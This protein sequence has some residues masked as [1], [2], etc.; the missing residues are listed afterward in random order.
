MLKDALLFPFRGTSLFVLILFSV[1]I[2]LVVVVMTLAYVLTE[3]QPLWMISIP[4]L[5]VLLLGLF[6]HCHGI[7]KS[8]IKL[9]RFD[10]Q[11]KLK[12]MN[13]K[14][15]TPA[16]RTLLFMLFGVV[17]YHY[18]SAVFSNLFV[19]I[20]IVSAPVWLLILALEHNWMQALRIG[21]WA[22]TIKI[23]GYYYL[24]QLVALTCVVGMIYYFLTVDGGAWSIIV[25]IYLLMAYHR[26]V[27][28]ILR[29][30]ESFVIVPESWNLSPEARTQTIEKTEL[31]K[32]QRIIH[33]MNKNEPVEI[34][35]DK[36]RIMMTR[37]GYKDSEHFFQALTFMESP[38]HA[39]AF[40]EHYLPYLSGVRDTTTSQLAS[41]ID[42]CFSIS[43][44]Y[45]L[46]KD[47]QNV[48]LAKAL[49][50]NGLDEQAERIYNRFVQERMDSDYV[51]AMLKLKPKSKTIK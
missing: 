20:I 43:E 15:N 21:L 2:P 46:K 48:M 1:T 22:H 6:N 33:A 41:A 47:H 39:I 28:L 8:S 17:C 40:C 37:Q 25:C 27:G 16:T 38:D 36:F 44:N 3:G 32:Y 5:Y 4:M 11:F 23:L 49:W 34:V 50:N 14:Q 13:P 30:Q 42:F 7:L 26:F 31:A 51:S 10:M 19:A 12:W 24:L 45:L 18:F 29:K 35:A 9:E